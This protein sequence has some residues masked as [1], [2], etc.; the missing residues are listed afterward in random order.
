MTA[1]KTGKAA[2]AGEGTRPVVTP[3][4]RG[5]SAG[6]RRV[7]CSRTRASRMTA[8]APFQ[9]RPHSSKRAAALW[10]PAFAGMT[11][12]RGHARERGSS[13]GQEGVMLANAGIQNDSRAPFQA[14]PHSSKRAA[15]LW[16]PAFAG[17][18]KA[19]GHARERGSSAGDRRVSC[20]RTRAS[21][22]TAAVPYQARPH[23]LKRAAAF[24]T[25]A[26]AGVT[27]TV[28]KR[29]E[30]PVTDSASHTNPSIPD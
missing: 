14:R 7:S 12:A 1:V 10:I 13:A 30:H 19:R 2:D 6:D 5:S 3:A 4:N 26:F 24:W 20:S 8:A 21:R 9:A 11:K 22:M 17:M 29:S 18:T 15:A 16:T 28:R 25:P 27:R 23:S